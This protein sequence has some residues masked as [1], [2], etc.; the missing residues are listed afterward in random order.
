MAAPVERIEV[1]EQKPSEARLAYTPGPVFPEVITPA[2]LET[3]QAHWSAAL[4]KCNADKKAIRIKFY[5]K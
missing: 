5:G 2:I 3:W 4:S 1:P